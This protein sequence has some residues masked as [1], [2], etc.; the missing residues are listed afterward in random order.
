MYLIAAFDK[1][2]HTASDVEMCLRLPVLAMV[3]KLAMSTSQDK[4]LRIISA[5]IP[6]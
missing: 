5:R 3:P 6:D 4:N 2:M 1:S